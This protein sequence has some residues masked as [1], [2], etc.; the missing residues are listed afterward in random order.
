MLTYKKYITKSILYPFITIAF[1]LTS[2]VWIM[3]ILRLINLIDKGVKLGHFL[4]IVV[5]IVPSLLFMI[6]PLVT[7][8]SVIFEYNKLQDERQ[9]IILKSS[10]LSNYDIAKPALFIAT[11][12]TLFSYYLSVYLMPLSYNSLKEQLSHLKENYV[13]NVIDTK[14]FNQI[15]KNVTIYADQKDEN[16]QLK[17]VIIFDNRDSNSMTVLFAKSGKLIMIDNSPIFI[18]NHGFRQA[19]DKENNMTKLFFNE[20][21]VEIQN[22]SDNSNRNK[23]S[24]ELFI[25]EMIWPDATIPPE[26]QGNL[27][28]DAHQRILWP[29]F[30]LVFTFLAISTFLRSPYNRKNHIKQNIITFIPVVISAYLHFTLQKISYEDSNYV[31]LS[32]LNVILAIIFSFW[33][34]NRKT[35]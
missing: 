8:I 12:A 26:K 30:N 5:L 11:L 1:I 35:I 20:L 22:K 15:S 9:L 6:L 16:D 18:L 27:L 14:T 33:Q 34:S 28:I 7:I 32:Y 25:H 29:L 10:G 13:S 17:G 19:Y 3:Q 24:L 23:T 4:Q 31:I 2:F 21:S